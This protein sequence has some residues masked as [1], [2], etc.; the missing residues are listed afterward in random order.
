[1]LHTSTS[2]PTSRSLL[3]GLARNATCPSAIL[4]HRDWRSDAYLSSALRQVAES[5]A[6][7]EYAIVPCRVM[8]SYLYRP[9]CQAQY[10][11]RLVQILPGQHDSDINC[12]IYDYTLRS[13]QAPGPYEALSYA[14]GDSKQR[15]RIYVRDAWSSNE[16]DTYV[17]DAWSSNERDTSYL[18]VTANLFIALRRL[19]DSDFPRL[20]WIDALCIDQG[21][22]DERSTQVAFMV[23]VYAHAKSVLVW[24]GEEADGSSDLFGNLVGS[25]S[26]RESSVVEVTRET[27][28]AFLRRPW[29]TRI[30]VGH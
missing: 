18:D 6:P 8:E 10:S 15:Q 4:F 22:L 17:R 25:G 3:S 20:M 16:C 26:Q 9:L 27:V 11:T 30:W 24:L 12:I 7:F 21:N 14:W 19:R 1:M 5:S 28:I 23:L 13:G 2:T 29:F